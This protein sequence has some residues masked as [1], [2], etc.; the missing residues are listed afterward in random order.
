V[1]GHMEMSDTAQQ[2]TL[3]GQYGE[4]W[5]EGSR[6][7]ATDSALMIDWSDSEH[8]AYIHA[9]TLFTEELH[10]EDSA[11]QDSTYYRV[12]GYYGVRVYRDDV[13]MVCDSMVYWGSDSTIHLYMDPISWSENHQFSADSMIVY[14][15]NGTVDHTLGIGKALCV[16]HDSL[17]FFNQMSGKELTAYLE[18][19]EVRTVDVSGNARTI[20][21][22]R[23]EDG[24]Y[25][26]L[27]TTES[28][29]IRSYV[30]N[31]EVQ[32]MRFTKETTGVLYP[33][34][35]IPE[36][37]DRLEDFFWEEESRPTGPMDVFRKVEIKE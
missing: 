20:Y 12:K 5:E 21:Y 1:L 34:D 2:A 22:P 28:S 19:G 17:E 4:M 29:F 8:L 36:G 15:A 27:N 26:G 10:Y 16:M 11:M 33:M 32:R 24:D 9:D 25:V 7:Y 18:D 35:Q 30:E 3:Y 14:M 31:Q 6:G 13:Q 23:E 37:A